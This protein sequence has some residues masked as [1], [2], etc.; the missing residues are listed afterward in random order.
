MRKSTIILSILA[1]AAVVLMAGFKAIPK[2]YAQPAGSRT[3]S[4]VVDITG[5]T[6]KDVANY[7]AALRA[8]GV[9]EEEIEAY[10]KQMRE[11]ENRIK[12]EVAETHTFSV[13]VDA[14][15]VEGYVAALRKQ[16]VSEET[17]QK[18]KDEFVK[19]QTAAPNP[20][21][22]CKRRTDGAEAYNAYHMLLYSYSSTV[23]WCYNG[24]TITSLST[25]EKYSTYWGWQFGGSSSSRSGGVGSFSF[26]IHRYATM[27]NRVTGAVKHPSTHQ[28]VYANGYS[29]GSASTG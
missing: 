24:S 29:W 3:F 14:N 1:M 4:V 15:D 10:V 20:K 5:D 27:Y 16:G 23:E 8:Q 12:K 25:W 21:N 9:S 22:S 17:I 6:E 26:T 11:E 19:H 28:S 2:S 13:V 18:L 7:A